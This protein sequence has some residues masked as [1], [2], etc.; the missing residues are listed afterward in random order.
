MNILLDQ[1]PI[2]VPEGFLIPPGTP[3]LERVDSAPGD[4]YE[5]AWLF[6]PSGYTEPLSVAERMVVRIS[7]EHSKD[8]SLTFEGKI[9]LIKMYRDLVDGLGEITP[10]QIIWRP[11][12]LF[13]LWHL[14][15]GR[16]AELTLS[17]VGSFMPA[18]VYPYLLKVFSA[19]HS[20][21]TCTD[22]NLIQSRLEQLLKGDLK[23]VRQ[24]NAL[25]VYILQGVEPR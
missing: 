9:R 23:D 5:E 6:V 1:F 25:N 20:V 13:L 7:N 10:P 24:E 15:D 8:L 18:H 12:S 2:Q 3:L 16:R 21:E 22:F 17:V 11:K 14:P 4:P 19:D